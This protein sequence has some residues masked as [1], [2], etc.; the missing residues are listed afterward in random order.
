[1]RF[2]GL[3]AWRLGGLEAWRLGGLEAWRLGG[4]E[5]WR[6]EKQGFIRTQ[7]KPAH[8]KYQVLGYWVCEIPQN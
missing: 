6:L 7:H 5:A 2:G 1:M 3:E 8:S 4:L